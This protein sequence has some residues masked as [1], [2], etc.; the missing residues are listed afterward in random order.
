MFNLGWLEGGLIILAA[1]LVFGPKRLPGL[2]RSLAKA[3]RGI[4][5]EVQVEEA[6]EK[7]PNDLDS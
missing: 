5:E 7:T 2:G 1:V 6:N 3:L 4:R